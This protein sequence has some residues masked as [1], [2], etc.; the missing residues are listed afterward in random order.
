MKKC[1]RVVWFVFS[2]AYVAHAQNT[3]P[4]S[5]NVGIGTTSPPNALSLIGPGSTW[6][7]FEKT[8][9]FETGFQFRKAGNVQFYFYSDN[10]DNDALKIQSTV[11]S[12]ENDATPRIQIPYTSKNLYFVQSGGYVGVGTSS[13]S[14][15]LHI[16]SE[17]E[18]ESFRLYKSGNTTNYLS[19]WQGV[20]AAA[21]DPIGTGKLYLGYDQ[22]T[23]VYMGLNSGKVGVGTTAPQAK[24]HISDGDLLLQNQVA[25]YPRLWLKDQTGAYTLKLDYNSVIATGSDMLIR[26]STNKNIILN[27]TG[28]NVGIGTLTTGS[29]RLA[30]EGKIGAREVNVTTSAWSDYVFKEDYSLRPI[31]DVEKYIEENHHLPE[32]PSEKEV[33]ANGQNLGEM[34]AILLK[35]IEELTLYIIDQQKEIDALKSKVDK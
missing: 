18:R 12:G 3:F 24:L 1:I 4:S 15:R 11:L 31:Y 28:G 7:S 17:I 22:S 34:N 2:L 33:L 35:K 29:Y 8:G 32:V 16:N 9:A 6:L 14:A 25:G 30:V 19:L 13:P 23:E 20:G 27:D 10:D 26:A 5:G 21:I